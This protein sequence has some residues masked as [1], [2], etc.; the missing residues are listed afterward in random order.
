MMNKLFLILIVF[1]I[2]CASSEVAQE[3]AKKKPTRIN[4]YKGHYT[5]KYNYQIDSLH[6][7]YYRKNGISPH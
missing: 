6:R 2:G 1:G 5:D 4:N 7:E 3:P